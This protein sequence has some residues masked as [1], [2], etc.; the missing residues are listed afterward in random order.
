MGYLCGTT[1]RWGWLDVCVFFKRITHPQFQRGQ[2]QFFVFDFV[3]LFE[4][5]FLLEGGLVR[6]VCMSKDTHLTTQRVEVIGGGHPQANAVYVR[7]EDWMN[8]PQWKW[9]HAFLVI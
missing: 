8:Q 7:I 1:H 2:N 5:G 3:S 6:I 9:L 4:S